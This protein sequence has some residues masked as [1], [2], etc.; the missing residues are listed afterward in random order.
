MIFQLEICYTD[1]GTSLFQCRLVSSSICLFFFLR[2]HQLRRI[3]LINIP[4]LSLQA[5][6]PLRPGYR[7]NSRLE[8]LWLGNKSI[9]S[10]SELPPKTNDKIDDQVLGFL[11]DSETVKQF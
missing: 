1:T 6:T 2:A 11:L 3:D 4:S 10:T 8:C 5:L 9:D 7:L